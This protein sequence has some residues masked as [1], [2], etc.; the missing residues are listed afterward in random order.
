MAG[1]RL[2][3]VT[4]SDLSRAPFYAP[5]EVSKK[6]LR[7]LRILRLHA[8]AATARQRCGVAWRKNTD[9]MKRYE[10]ER[11]LFLRAPLRKHPFASGHAVD[12][13]VVHAFSGPAYNLEHINPYQA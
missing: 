6:F 7:C 10:G 3:Q 1:T 8:F 2:L 12:A 5:P 9:D 13:S 11:P 4:K